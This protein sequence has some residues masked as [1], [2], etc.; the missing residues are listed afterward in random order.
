M[1][2]SRGR[3]LVV[4]A[5]I[6]VLAGCPKPLTMGSLGPAPPASTPPVASNESADPPVS[7]AGG[8][9]TLRFAVMWPEEDRRL[10][11]IPGETQAIIFSYEKTALQPN[12][13]PAKGSVTLVRDKGASRVTGNFQLFPGTYTIRVRAYATDAPIEGQ[14]LVLASGAKPITV[15]PGKDAAVDIEL[16]STIPDIQAIDPIHAAPAEQITILGS[17]FGGPG[18]T[19]KVLFPPSI[20]VTANRIDDTTLRVA[21]PSGAKTGELFVR[22]GQLQ[23]SA[24]FTSLKTLRIAT[25]S[26]ELLQGQQY[27]LVATGT[28]SDDRPIAA[29]S[30][31]WLIM[32][33]SGLTLADESGSAT[34]SMIIH[35][36]TPGDSVVRAKNGNLEATSNVHVFKIN[37]VTLSPSAFT[38]GGLPLAGDVAPGYTSSKALTATVH[39]SDNRPRKVTWSS[40][41]PTRATV[42][43]N[44]L[45]SS[46]RGAVDGTVTITA[47]SVDDPTISA[48]VLCT[49]TAF[50]IQSVTLSPTAVTLNAMPEEGN[51]DPGFETTATLTA[52]VAASDGNTRQVIWSSS[53]ESRVTVTDGVVKTVRG[54][55]EGTVTI[56]ATSVDDPKIS[57]TATV[58]VTANGKISVGVN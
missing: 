10:Q 50:K 38:L 28:D 32:S 25:S 1:H 14:D 16:K 23:G 33:G 22:V 18:S 30:A 9:Q 37:G 31:R 56:T 49:I 45:V 42:D 20:E 36:L 12:E 46:Q 17:N 29:A 55:D 3:V 27:R 39:A 51:P 13:P 6:G 26:I 19:V 15:E 57:A 43:G 2:P 53:D 4:L 48:S 35:A 34:S 58:H 44:G 11:A 52:V 41:D 40:S 7:N 24:S 47:T 5:S 8:R 54:A 21:V